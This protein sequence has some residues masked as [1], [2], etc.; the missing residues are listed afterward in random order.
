M[1]IWS[2]HLYFHVNGEWIRMK[3]QPVGC[4][5][6]RWFSLWLLWGFL[7]WN[8]MRIC[9]SSLMAPVKNRSDGSYQGL[10]MDWI[11]KNAGVSWDSS[12]EGSCA[13]LEVWNVQRVMIWLLQKFFWHGPSMGTCNFFVMAPAMDGILICTR[14]LVMV[15]RQLV[16]WIR[17]QKLQWLLQSPLQWFR[18]VDNRNLQWFLQ[19]LLQK[20]YHGSY[21]DACV[22]SYDSSSGDSVW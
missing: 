11:V 15:Y 2:I 8:R 6:L 16:W 20:S 7:W 17:S 10:E 9:I 4:R 19:W 18:Q 5:K 22:G 12:C 1:S 13:Q 21:A 14:A 3:W